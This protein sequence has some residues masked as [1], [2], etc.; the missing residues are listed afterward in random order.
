MTVHFYASKLWLPL[1]PSLTKTCPSMTANYPSMTATCL[2]YDRHLPLLWLPITFLQLLL[3]PSR[4][5]IWN[6]KLFYIGIINVLL[7]CLVA[8]MFWKLHWCFNSVWIFGFCFH[9]CTEPGRNNWC[10]SGSYVWNATL[11]LHWKGSES[12]QNGWW[13]V[14]CS[15][16]G[17]LLPQAFSFFLNILLLQFLWIFGNLFWLPEAT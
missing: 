3:T 15:W 7:C 2:F 17:M 16:Q 9:L 5:A 11:Y 10:W 8:L 13:T 14:S 1:A 6:I 4:T 12:Q